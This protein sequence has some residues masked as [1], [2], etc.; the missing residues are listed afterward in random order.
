VREFPSVDPPLIT[1]STSYRGAS[2]E[3]VES[4]ITEPLEEAINAV[5][6]IRTLTSVSREGR[7]T[8][9]V[10]FDLGADLERAANDIRD[11]VSTAMG[12]LP[13]DAD[14]PRVSKADSDSPPIVGIT[15]QSDRR[16][17]LE[18]S[19]LAE[20]T[21]VERLQTVSDVSGVDVWGS[22]E[23]S[24]RLWID[25][26]RLAAYGLALLDVRQAVQRESVELPAGRLEG[27]TVELA[28]RTT[29]R[30][31]TPEAFEGLI[32][33]EDAGGVVR[34]RD[35]GRAELGALNNRTVLKKGG[36][37]MVAVVTRP[38]P[39]ANS[40][41]GWSG[42]AGSCRR[43]SP[44]TCSSTPPATCGSRCARCSRPS[45]SPSPWWCW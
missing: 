16:N 41:A 36:V 3:V 21:L 11:R 15:V 30:L 45:S 26:G 9:Q 23:Y 7:S 8:I 28:L 35:V 20:E 42:S 12:R 2:P 38:Q 10:E 31:D 14:P 17:L 5:A 29:T 40:I 37:P 13:A 24:M 43:T 22:Q 33:K 39:G 19:R 25:S 34:F 18:L 1:V 44:W 32:L 6:G 27:E 4:Q